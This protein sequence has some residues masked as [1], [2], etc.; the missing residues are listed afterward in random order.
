MLERGNTADAGPLE[1]LLG[2]PLRPIRSFI[3]EPRQA[4]RAAQLDWLLPLLRLSLALL[5][6]WTA[7]VAAFLYPAAASYELLAR[8]GVPAA[9]A[10]LLLYGACALD[11]AFG[12]ASVALPRRWRG[13]LWLAQAALIVFYSAVIALRLPAFLFH[14]Y[15]PLS[16]N[17]PILA[18]LLLLYHVEKA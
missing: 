7:I 4:R 2:R 9:A 18:M 14:P 1:R 12:L 13:L 15:G 10:P 5:W 17:L 8:S 11:L 3:A 16:K 6:I